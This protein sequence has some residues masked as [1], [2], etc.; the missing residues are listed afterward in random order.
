MNKQLKQC[1]TSAAIAVAMLLAFAGA[2]QNALAQQPPG[3]LNGGMASV[4]TVSPTIA[5]VGD[6]V[7]ISQLGVALGGT[8]CNVTNGQSFIM[9]P[10]GVVANAQ[11][12]ETNF[13]ILQGQTLTCLPTPSSGDASCRAVTLSYVIQAADQNRSLLFTTPRGFTSGFVPGT[14][15]LIKFLVVSD[16]LLVGSA[17]SLP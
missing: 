6:T 5:H 3:C 4:I 15:K 7:T 1:R 13:T 2:K 10:D 9:Y 14:P 11:Q 12:Y 8:S 16:G 17:G